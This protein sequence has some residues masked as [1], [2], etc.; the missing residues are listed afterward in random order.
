MHMTTS[1]VQI[2][3]W[4]AFVIVLCIIIWRR[5]RKTAD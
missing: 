1:M 2:A 5:R 3:A 4:I